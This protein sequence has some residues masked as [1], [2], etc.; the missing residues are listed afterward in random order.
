MLVGKNKNKEA[1]LNQLGLTILFQ[2]EN[3]KNGLKKE[4]KKKRGI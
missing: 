3:C 4:R 2:Q 1:F